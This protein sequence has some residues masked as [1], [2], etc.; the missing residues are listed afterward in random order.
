LALK[1]LKKKDLKELFGTIRYS[2][3]QHQELLALSVDETFKEAK[4]LIV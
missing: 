3:L 1:K 4:D 2:Y